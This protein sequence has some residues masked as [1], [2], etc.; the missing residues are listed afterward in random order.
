MKFFIPY[1]FIAAALACTP[2]AAQES[3]WVSFSIV[4]AGTNGSANVT[5]ATV[6]ARVMSHHRNAG[7]AANLITGMTTQT[8]SVGYANFYL[9]GSGRGPLFF[10]GRVQFVIDFPQRCPVACEIDFY[11]DY[12]PGNTQ[13]SMGETRN[14]TVDLNPARHGN[15]HCDGNHVYDVQYQRG[16]RVHTPAPGGLPVDLVDVD[17]AY[18]IVY[19]DHPDHPVHCGLTR[20]IDRPRAPELLQ[21]N[22]VILRPQV[23]TGPV[24]PTRVQPSLPRN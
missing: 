18:H 24:D 19:G 1:I 4:N 20:Q 10:E 5:G 22:P 6:C 17:G 15:F 14:C 2:A 9:P 21:E 7:D 13:P 23:P 11:W 3:P 12:T 8:D 16:Q